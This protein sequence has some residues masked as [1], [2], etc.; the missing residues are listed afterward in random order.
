MNQTTEGRFW[1][2]VEKNPK[3]CWLWRGAKRSKGY[4]AFV[5]ARG[6]EV[7][8]GRAHR[9]SWEIHNGEIPIDMCVLHKCDVPACV[10]PAH[11]W[12]GTK[13]ENNLD[14]ARKGRRVSGG[15]HCGKNGKWPRGENHSNSKLLS[16]QVEELHKDRDKGMSYSQLS[17][18]YGVCSTQC[19]RI[20]K[21]K[22]WNNV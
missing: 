22:R 16:R 18:K 11:L 4:G 10:N 20:I 7:V 14:M 9:Y 21:G 8:Q 1:A 19:W 5:Y 3:G 6:G 2:K 12:L 15:T 13:A 17:N